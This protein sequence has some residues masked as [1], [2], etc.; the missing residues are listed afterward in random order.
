M[1]AS[2]R[3][4]GVQVDAC[5]RGNKVMGTSILLTTTRIF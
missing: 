2:S 1:S 3:H 5:T 4:M